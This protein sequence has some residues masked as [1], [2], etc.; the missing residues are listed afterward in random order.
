VEA[1]MYASS[2]QIARIRF[3]KYG[4]EA[5]PDATFTLRLSYGAAKGYTSAEGKPVALVT[6]TQLVLG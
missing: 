3:A 1:S 6:Q 5:Y 4:T 2:S